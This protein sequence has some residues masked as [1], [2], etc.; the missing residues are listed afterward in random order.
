MF[1]YVFT[2]EEAK[3]LKGKNF[4]F[5]CNLKIG[6]KLAYV[7]EDTRLLN[8]EKENIKAYKTNKIYF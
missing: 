7:F 8:F 4:P 6:E 2:L 1:V 5:I 3:I